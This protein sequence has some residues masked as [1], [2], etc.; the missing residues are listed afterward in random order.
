MSEK[1]LDSA[2]EM[3][4]HGKSP[5][6]SK[7]NIYKIQEKPLNP[8]ST[9]IGGKLKIKE[10]RSPIVDLFKENEKIS[11]YLGNVEPSNPFES[12]KSIRLEKRTRENLHNL[13]EICTK[14]INESVFHHKAMSIR[15]NS[16][17]KLG[18]VDLSL[19]DCNAIIKVDPNNIGAHY[20]RG[21]INQ[22][23]KNMEPAIHDF[24][25][26]LKL[27]PNHVNAAFARASC[28]N[29]IG[30][31]DKAIQDY[32]VGLLKDKKRDIRRRTGNRSNIGSRSRIG[33]YG[34]R[35][36]N[37]ENSSSTSLLA[38]SPLVGQNLD[39]S[40]FINPDDG[41]DN[42]ENEENEEE[43]DLSLNQSHKQ[44]SMST[45]LST[46]S[47]LKRTSNKKNLEEADR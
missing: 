30:E 23:K 41:D 14:K 9:K 45:I 20:L 37:K 27:D 46:T 31:F 5:S 26:V 15:A 7:Y 12:K 16:Y 10:I 47:N 42:Y 2:V 43:Y 18:K 33:S 21:S 8:T 11:K 13:I 39:N 19:L 1:L 4:A 34:N 35:T 24:S 22:R 44:K 40:D 29:F 36:D 25:I 3:S 28:Y 6:G 17:M 32:E 38:K